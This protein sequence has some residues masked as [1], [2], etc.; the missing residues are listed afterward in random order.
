[1]PDLNEQQPAGPTDTTDK[2]K[3]LLKSQH[4]IILSLVELSK[5]PDLITVYFNSGKESI[6]TTVIDV[7]QER[8]LVLLEC[9]RDTEKNRQLLAAGSANCLSKH[10][11]IE[12]RFQL[13]ELR[14]ARYQGQIVLAAP[15][16]ESLMRLQR[17]EFFRVHTPISAPI[18]CR[19]ISKG[20]KK[21]VLP[22]AD[23]SI[24]GLCLIDIEEQFKGE[25]GDTLEG[26]TLSF[27]EH[28]EEMD[29]DLE[30]RSIFTQGK[31]GGQKVRR[32]GCAYLELP[33]DKAGFIQRYISR[34]QLKQQNLSRR[35]R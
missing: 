19:L 32:I 22:L 34:L 5:K 17:R 16:P 35:Q 15:I 1:M 10:N 21:L 18:N 29:L 30:V 24:G 31:A 7:L 20:G 23:I 28:A 4:E 25:S 11:D 33:P 12:I 13:S 9:G 26:V 27:P 2:D 8:E 3:Y 6:I 14:S